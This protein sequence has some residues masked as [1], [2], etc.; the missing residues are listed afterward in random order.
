MIAAYESL[1]AAGWA[2]SIEIW[3][4]DGL[5]GAVYGLCIGRMFFGESMFSGKP[6]T[7]KIA[8]LGLARHMQSHNMLLLDCQAQGRELL[9]IVAQPSRPLLDCG[10]RGLQKQRA[11]HPFHRRA[12]A[13]QHGLRGLHGDTLQRRT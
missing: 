5:I 1:H 4:A 9:Q 13:H 10:N 8:L 12:P 6:N 3:D 2:H 7:S 11:S